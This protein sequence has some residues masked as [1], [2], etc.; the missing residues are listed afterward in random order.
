MSDRPFYAVIPAGGSGTR[1]W[2]ASRTE[3]PKFLH[4]LTGSERTLL[5]AT[6]DRLEPLAPAARTYVV[7]GVAHAVGVS[8]QLPAL[9]VENILVE[10]SPR[11]S[12]AA[13]GLA[14]MVIARR[15][16]T[17]VMGSFAADHLVRHQDRFVAAV[18]TAVET[19]ADGYLITIGITPTRPETGYGYLRCGGL[20][21]GG[22][23]DCDVKLVGEFVEKPSREVAVDYV[24]SGRYLWNAGMF[25]WTVEA[26]LAELARQQPELHSGLRKIVEAWDGPRREAVLG[27]VWPTLPKISVDYAVMEGAAAASRVATVQCDLGWTDV[28]DFHALGEVLPADATGNVVIT[29]D[30][31]GET[32]MLDSHDMVLVPRSGRMV[33]ALGV[34]DLIV[35]DT[36]DAVLVCPRN[37]AQ[38]VKKLVEKLRESGRHDLT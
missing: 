3:H 7:T 22:G 21:H 8:R 4:H 20:L 19:A 26:F 29:G 34:S 36:P 9:P 1:L 18:R 14:A 16:P 5:Q 27:E 25:V 24:S 15:E 6:V 28:G 35:V 33:A 38:D 17:A 30:G 37:R 31:A 11:D 32:L 10:P 23:R 2:P 13:I 12:C